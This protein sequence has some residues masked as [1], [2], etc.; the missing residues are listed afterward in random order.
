M[1]N[2]FWQVFQASCCFC[3]KKDQF[4][5]NL[6]CFGKERKKEKRTGSE[7]TPEW[8]TAHFQLC[9]MTGSPVS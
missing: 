4:T 1:I 6:W 7:G 3:N 2:T 5:L 9:V 8:A